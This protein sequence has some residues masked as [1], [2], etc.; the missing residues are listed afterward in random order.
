MSAASAAEE[1]GFT[2]TADA[3]ARV[4]TAWSSVSAFPVTPMIGPEK[5]SSPRSRRVASYPSIGCML[6]SIRMTSNGS[7]SS[8]PAAGGAGLS[9]VG[10]CARLD[11]DAI[12]LSLTGRP[13]PLLSADRLLSSSRAPL[14]QSK[15]AVPSAASAKVLPGNSR[16]RVR[17]S[18]IRLAVTSSTMRARSGRRRAPVGARPGTARGGR[19]VPESAIDGPEGTGA[20]LCT[21][22]TP[23]PSCLGTVP[24]G[25]QTRR[26]SV[27]VNVDPLPGPEDDAVRLPPWASAIRLLIDR[28][29]PVPPPFCLL[30]AEICAKGTKSF[31]ASSAVIPQP[32][33]VT[34]TTAWTQSWEKVAGAVPRLIRKR[35]ADGRDQGA[36]ASSCAP[37][38][39][40]GS[41]GAASC[42]NG[43]AELASL[44][45]AVSASSRSGH[46]G[47]YRSK[48]TSTAT[49][50]PGPVNLCALL[51]TFRTTCS[52]FASS[53]SVS[54]PCL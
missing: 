17:R 9:G 7:R 18:M 11:G 50:P 48:T 26:G 39:S 31:P 33:S 47:D 4:N 30:P 36:I 44:L 19:A 16:A 29:S 43:G 37:V 40:A 25:M 6:P 54:V 38:K 5:C 34:V 28:P 8:V 2:C 45:I 13:R 32:E 20:R 21:G 23:L 15:A 1:T 49:R 46:G 14:T 35:I 24:F 22:V 52:S 27:R 3:P 42:W 41:A 12:G 53:N 51:S 10:A